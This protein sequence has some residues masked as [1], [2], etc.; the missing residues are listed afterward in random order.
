MGFAE[1]LQAVADVLFETAERAAPIAEQFIRARSAQPLPAAMPSMQAS[2]FPLALP[3]SFGGPMPGAGSIQPAAFL[4][5]FPGS[6]AMASP[7]FRPG[8]TGARPRSLIIQQN[9]FTGKPTFFKHAGTPIL[10]SGDLSAARRVQRV[11]RRAKRG[12]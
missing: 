4:G 10:F 6:D 11:A 9:P 12:R 1:G 3:A 8:M 7:F 5:D 2:S